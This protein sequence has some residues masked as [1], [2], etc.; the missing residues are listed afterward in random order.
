MALAAPSKSSSKALLALAGCVIVLAI[1]SLWY[2][3]SGS[4]TYVGT[5]AFF[6]DDDGKTFFVDTSSNL[7]PFSHGGRD[8]VGARVFLDASG[9]PFVGYLERYTEAGKARTRE[10]LAERSAGKGN[11]GKDDVLLA[12]MELKRPNA[13]DW[14]RAADPKAAEIR[15]VMCPDKPT[16]P[17]MPHWPQAK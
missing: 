2:F 3:W 11:P 12:N 7:P 15:K 9:K 14:T 4:S 16:Q 17:A 10:L 13:K 5:D 8:A 6:S 1:V